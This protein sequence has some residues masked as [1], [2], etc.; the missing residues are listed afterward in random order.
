MSM[1]DE[2]KKVAVKGYTE[3]TDP[4]KVLANEGKE[5][6]ER[7]LRWIDKVAGEV[8]GMPF[9]AS[10]NPVALAMLGRRS[11]QQGFMWVVR[12]IFRPERIS[13]PEDSKPQPTAS[14]SN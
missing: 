5:L 11:I 2:V 13:L 14:E 7:V 10:D 1:T 4:Q 8:N 6:E 12:A 9:S 3:L